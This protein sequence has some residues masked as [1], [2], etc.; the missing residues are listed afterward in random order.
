MFPEDDPHVFG[1]PQALHGLAVHFG[2]APLTWY[3]LGALLLPAAVVAWRR[4]EPGIRVLLT[5]AAV[6][7]AG[8]AVFWGPWNF[9]VVWRH[10]RSVFGPV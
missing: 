5:C 6:M 1:L 7:L 4:P 3:A 8:Y 9:S 10:G 2:V